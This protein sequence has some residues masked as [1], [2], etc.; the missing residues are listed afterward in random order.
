LA[1]AYALRAAGLEALGDFGESRSGRYLQAIRRFMDMAETVMRN[2]RRNEEVLALAY[3]DP[4]MLGGADQYENMRSYAL[5]LPWR[6]NRWLISQA[7]SKKFVLKVGRDAGPGQKPGGPSDSDT[8]MWVGMALGKVAVIGGFKKE[9][10][11]LISEIVPRGTSVMTIGYH[12]DAITLETAREAGKDAQ[13]ILPDVLSQGDMEAH[14]GQAHGEISEGLANMASDDL[15]QKSLGTQ[16]VDALLA[17]KDAH[18]QA[19]MEDELDRMPMASSRVLRHRVWMRKLRVGEDVGWNPAVYDTDDTDYWWVRKLWTLAQVRASD[20]FTDDFKAVVEGFDA[21]NVSGVAKGG[22]TASSENMGSDAR[23]AMTEEALDPDEMFVEFFELWFRYPKMRAGGIRRIVCSETPEMFC[24]ADDS[25]PYVNEKGENSI[26]GF[27]PF[28]DFTPLRSSLTVPERTLGIPP[29]AVGMTQF[30]RI[31]EYNRLR[32]A[33]ALRHS[34]RLYQ[35][36]PSLRE[37]EGVKEALENGQDGYC[38]FADGMVDT[39]GR[40][41]DAVIPVQFTGNTQEIDRQAAREVGDY[42]NVMGMPP[43]IYQGMGTAETATQDQQGIAA[44]EQETSTVIDYFETRMSDVFAGIRGLMR[45]NYDDEDFVPML[46]EMGAQ[47]LK[48]WQMGSEDIGDEI[49][50][51]FGRRAIAQATVEKKQLMEA[52]GLERAE[53]DPVSGL[54]LY[55]STQLFEELHRRLEVGPP[56][57]N[58]GVLLALQ[59]EVLTLRSQMQA[60]LDFVDAKQKEAPKGGK[61][62]KKEGGPNPSEGNGPSPQNLNAG[63]RRDTVLAGPAQDQ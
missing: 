36:H 63:A 41:Q 47:I 52:I 39:S 53:V 28:W 3:H 30:E 16:G 45:G 56:K 51:T 46:G 7:T 18:D 25:N 14:A 40:M 33:S 2:R 8:G 4:T 48:A 62:K 23:Q 31:T 55:D 34:V 37:Q 50:L 59:Q 10:S 58:Q 32:G 5:N 22:K 54:P 27:Y 29:M 61:T 44:G 6:Y 35:L 60:L 38:F 19:A 49:E 24:E 20:L 57:P 15:V 17:R 1:R 12:E 43:A 13:S 42:L 26:P 21:R 9:T 11:D